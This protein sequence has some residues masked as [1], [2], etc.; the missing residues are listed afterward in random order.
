[1]RNSSAKI[2]D[3]SSNTSLKKNFFLNSFYELLKVITPFI[4][5]P[6]ASRILGATNI[7]IYSYT[8]SVSSYF[9]MMAALGTATYGVREIART[10]LDKEIN[11]K[12]FWEIEFLSILTSTISLLIWGIYLYFV[13]Q[14]KFYYLILTLNI[15]NTMFDISWFYRGIEQ[16]KYLVTKNTLVK[17]FGI[18][19]LFVFVKTPE[20]LW[21]YILFHSG[22]SLAGTLTMWLGLPKFLIK[23]PFKNF[24]ILPHFKETLVYFIPSV[25][26]YVFAVLDKTLIGL[27]TKDPN[28]NGFYEQAYKIINIVKSLTYASINSVMCSRISFL[29]EQK[30]ISEVKKI[31]KKSI[32]L[33]LFMS[34]GSCFGLIGISSNFVP[35]FFGKGYEA[36]I[37]ILQ[38]LAPVIILSGFST[39]LNYQYF[40]PAGLRK[41]SCLFEVAGAIAN[42]IFNL[43]L[44]PR[45]MAIGA[46]IG[47]I[48]AEGVIALL[49]ISNAKDFLKLKTIL[50]VIWK[51]LI[52]ASIM[53][54][55]IYSIKQIINNELILLFTQILGGIFIYCILLIVLRDYN[56]FIIFNKIKSKFIKKGE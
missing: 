37:L 27:I 22:I 18:I 23:I 49:Y 47:T 52:S 12:I 44:I 11:T 48:I 1:M 19:C 39:C 13:P 35:L 34:I 21:L 28:Q 16:F 15:F 33:I 32:D 24:H 42:V 17:L 29:F 50:S 30:K 2:K 55:F 31:I 41:K 45:L 56:T 14:Y 38:L 51:K 5:A 36:S 40:I 8:N 43:I 46:V 54:I 20:D 7:G 3:S 9:T 26:V 4:T 6:Y 53:L 10:R 25:A